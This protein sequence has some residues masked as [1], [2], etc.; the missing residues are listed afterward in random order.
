MFW[1]AASDNLLAWHYLIERAR[2]QP[3]VAHGTLAR[4]TIE[5]AVMTRWLAEPGITAVEQRNRGAS[6]QLSDY[7]L[8]RQFEQEI[9]I[10]SAHRH[11]G[12]QPASIR[13]R[14]H[15]AEMR[16]HQVPPLGELDMTQLFRRYA[17][18]GR[19]DGAWLYRLVSGFAHGRPWA[20]ATGRLA[21]LNLPSAPAS[22][23]IVSATASDKGAALL[24]LTSVDVLRAALD[25][26]AA[27]LGRAEADV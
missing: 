14:D 13:E 3:M 12:G 11:E 8:R 18:H 17:V 6:A 22:G 7:R 1:V 23:R 20:L 21:D 9:G 16:A 24:A 25:D 26:L 15:R 27:Y 5:G 2:V 19:R 4:G 10:S